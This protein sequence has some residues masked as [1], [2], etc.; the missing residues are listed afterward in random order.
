MTARTPFPKRTAFV[1]EEIW[2]HPTQERQL[3]T[4]KYG[5]NEFINS[6]MTLMSIGKASQAVVACLLKGSF[7]EVER[8]GCHYEQ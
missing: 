3:V 2:K 5:F 1:R 8:E 7:Q 4:L 6:I